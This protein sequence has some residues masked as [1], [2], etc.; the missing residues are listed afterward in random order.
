MKKVLFILMPENYRDEEFC[1]PYNML[2]DK[3]YEI[4][5]AGFISGEAVGSEGHKHV[6][7]LV[8]NRLLDVDFDQ[9]DAIIIPG[10]SGST[11][12]LWDNEKLQKIIRYFHDNK[13]IVAAICHAVV[14][15]VQA[16]ILKNKKATVYPSDD[17]KEILEKHHVKFKDQGCVVLEN[18][19][20]I[21][22]QGPKFTK[23]F[24]QAIIDLLE[25]NN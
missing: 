16:G 3:N 20:I 5:V 25:K 8:L 24:G 22:S 18:E 4:D 2:K 10:G 17:A 13:K 21:T 6:P 9:Y 14:A 15:P 1:D 23:E 11:K 19:K 7:N 12:Y